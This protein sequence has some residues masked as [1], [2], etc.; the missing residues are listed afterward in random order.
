[1]NEPANSEGITYDSVESSQVPRPL[2]Y[3]ILL[4]DSYSESAAP[5]PLL[6][7][8]HGAGGDRKSLGQLKPQICK[9]IEDGTLP[10]LVAVTPSV[11]AGTIY[12]DDYYG[13]RSG[14]AASCRICYPTS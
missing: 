5:Y 7:L 2:E 12:M 14:K 13:K 1:M 10:P 6:L 4:P 3:S 8:L 9:S 11:P